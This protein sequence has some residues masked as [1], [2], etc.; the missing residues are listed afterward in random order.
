MANKW[1]EF[2]AAYRRRNPKV[3]MKQAMKSASVE[4][5]KSKSSKTTKKAKKGKKKK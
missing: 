5:K 2:L 3:S 4:W 1:L